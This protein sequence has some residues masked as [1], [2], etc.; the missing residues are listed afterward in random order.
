MRYIKTLLLPNEQ[1]LYDGH[2]H[3]RILLPSMVWLLV[4]A[5]ILHEASHTGGGRSILL[6]AIYALSDFSSMNS[7][8]NLLQNWQNRVPNIALEIKVVTLGMLIYGVYRFIYQFTVMTTTELVITNLRVISKQGFTTVTTQELD[9]RR[10]AGVIVQQTLLGRMFNFGTVFIQG[11]TNSIG[12][13]P[14][15]I[16]PHLVERFLS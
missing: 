9:R 13:M 12:G 10:I 8:Y 5:L 4:T 2:I 6:S 16:N 3:P 1:V 7:L 14:P 11:F 15:L